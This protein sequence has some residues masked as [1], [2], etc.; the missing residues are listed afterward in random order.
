MNTDLDT[1]RQRLQRLFPALSDLPAPL[2]AELVASVQI[3]AV[4]AGTLMFDAGAAC[5]ALPLVLEGSIRVSKRS[6]SGREIGL[7]R[8]I[9][10]EL[11]I[12]TLS[13]LLGGADYAATGVAVGPVR[14]ALLPRALFLKLVGTHP[15][16]REMVFHLYAE[17]L[18]DLMQ[19]V[20]EVAFHH[21][22]ER[23]AAWLAQQGPHIHLSHQAIAQELGSVREIVSRLLKQF[24]EAGW[25]RLDRGHVEVLDPVGL[26]AAHG[27]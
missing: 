22:D 25:V 19:L 17:R 18:V 12:V 9:P 27:T 13:C 16:F 4:P 23:L 3:L 2:A 11:C 26:L 8:V 21:L 7:Y 15:P 20:E 10:G 5:Q 24:E 1:E 14:L 6:E